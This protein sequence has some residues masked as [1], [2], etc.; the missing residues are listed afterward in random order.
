AALLASPGPRPGRAQQPADGLSRLA[1]LFLSAP[2]GLVE[3]QPG[4]RAAVT[5]ERHV[6]LAFPGLPELRRGR[7]G[8]VLST[9]GSSPGGIPTIQRTDG[10]TARCVSS[11]L[12]ERRNGRVQVRG[13]ALRGRSVGY[14]GATLGTEAWKRNTRLRR[15]GATPDQ[16]RRGSGASRG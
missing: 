6:G 16:C 7:R 1:G 3:K 2:G 11:Q 12:V 9:E 14:G 4:G 8:H 10:A 13:L 15:S 5:P